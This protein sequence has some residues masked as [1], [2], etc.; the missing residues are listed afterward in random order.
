MKGFC[1]RWRAGCL[2]KIIIARLEVWYWYTLGKRDEDLQVSTK[3]ILVRGAWLKRLEEQGPTK[4]GGR[5][6]WKG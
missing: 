6:I 2:A 4:R 3:G 1:Q 5:V